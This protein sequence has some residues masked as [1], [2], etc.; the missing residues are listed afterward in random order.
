MDRTTATATIDA[1]AD[2]LAIVRDRIRRANYGPR[3]RY[4]GLRAQAAA[5]EDQRMELI[6]ERLTLPA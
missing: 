5:L 6:L 4:L 2:A 3:R 1:L